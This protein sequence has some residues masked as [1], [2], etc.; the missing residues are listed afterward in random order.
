MPLITI[1]HTQAAYSKIKKEL[2]TLKTV[3]NYIVQA[4][5]LAYYV[6]LLVTKIGSIVHIVL[7]S[8]L[9]AVLVISFILELCMKD[10]QEDTIKEKKIRKQ[11]KKIIKFVIKIVKYLAKIGTIVVAIIDIWLNGGT[12]LGLILV[13]VSIIMVLMNILVDGIVYLAEKYFSMLYLAVQLDIDN[14]EAIQVVNNII[15]EVK[16]EEEKEQYF[17]NKEI[18]TMDYLKN[19]VSTNEEDTKKKPTLGQRLI[20]S[21]AKKAIKKALKNNE[22][23]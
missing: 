3:I 9:L 6:Y 15:K 2:S 4:L 7:Y 17:T 1:K 23:N 13:A 22:N 10:K 14:S 5:F 18:K 16:G 11:N 19:S 20:K 8:V 21:I 12:D